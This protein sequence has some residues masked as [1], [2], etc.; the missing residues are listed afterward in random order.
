MRAGGRCPRTAR[1]PCERARPCD[2]FRGQVPREG[3]R[4]RPSVPRS[5]E[6]AAWKEMPSYSAGVRQRRRE[7]NRLRESPRRP[8]IEEQERA[9]RARARPGGRS[10]RPR[11]ERRGETKARALRPKRKASSASTHTCEPCAHAETHDRPRGTWA[12]P[13]MEEGRARY[14]EGP[15]RE[16]ATSGLSPPAQARG[17]NSQQQVGECHG[18][19]ESRHE[20]DAVPAQIGAE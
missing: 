19:M 6:Q 17:A 16:R 18:R 4:L 12:D 15:G 3:W 1:G 14:T 5:A 11:G 8:G 2:G 10:G 9:E 13:E 7:Q 20:E